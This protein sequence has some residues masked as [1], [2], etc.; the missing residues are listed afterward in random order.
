MTYESVYAQLTWDQQVAIHAHLDK[1]SD[2]DQINDCANNARVAR[3]DNP[4]EVAWYE[5]QMEGGCCGFYDVVIEH[6]DGNILLGWNY[7]H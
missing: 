6:P 5:A 3:A 7:G 4:E 2:D 1:T